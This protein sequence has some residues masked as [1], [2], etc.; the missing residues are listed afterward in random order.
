MEISLIDQ[1]SKKKVI[2]DITIEFENFNNEN[3]IVNVKTSFGEVAAP[4]SK[5]SAKL[6]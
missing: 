2:E 3:E 1:T 6:S 5:D 4:T